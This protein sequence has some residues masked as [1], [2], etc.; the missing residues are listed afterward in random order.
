MKPALQ[1]PLQGDGCHC[2]GPLQGWALKHPQI[3][4]PAWLAGRGP[5]RMYPR[6]HWKPGFGQLAAPGC[7]V[8]ISF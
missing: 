6:G 5:L 4:Q 8:A 3:P 7:A 2:K 1:G